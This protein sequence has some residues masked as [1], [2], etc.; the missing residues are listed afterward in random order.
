MTARAPHAAAPRTAVRSAASHSVHSVVA[1]PQTMAVLP[2]AAVLPL[3]AALPSAA[4]PKATVRSRR[5]AA[6]P[7]VRAVESLALST[8]RESSE[9][10]ALA[11]HH[12]PVEVTMVT[13][14]AAAP[15]RSE[16]PVEV[17]LRKAVD[18]PA[19]V[20]TAPVRRTSA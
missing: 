12:C 20:P 17:V 16:Q 13:R 5:Q 11:E 15:A 7:W 10:L 6:P 8:S 19:V 4:V 18:S 1:E 9:A 14:M 3:V 2:L